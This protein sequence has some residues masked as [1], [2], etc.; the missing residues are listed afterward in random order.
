MAY[1]ILVPRPGIEPGSSAVKARSPN[2]WTAR[3][4][5]GQPFWQHEESQPKRQDWHMAEWKDMKE[6]EFNNAQVDELAN[7]GTVPVSL[8]PFPSP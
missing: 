4:F 7:S 5:P 8:N 6:T 1:G 3:E 2:H